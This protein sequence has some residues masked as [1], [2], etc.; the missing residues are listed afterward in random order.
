MYFCPDDE[1]AIIDDL[2]RSMYF[3][4]ITLP[5]F[6][7]GDADMALKKLT[8]DIASQQQIVDSCTK[9]IEVISQQAKQEILKAYSKLCY[10]HATFELRK[11]VGFMSGKFYIKGFVPK[12]D[13]KRFSELMQGFESLVVSYMPPDADANCTPPTILKNSWFTRPFRMLVEMY[14]LPN[15]NGFNPTAFVAVTYTLLFGIMFGDLGQ[16]F[17]VVRCSAMRICSIR[18]LNSSAQTSCR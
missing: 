11:K 12:R 4:R 17:L 6:V 8:Q 5:D 13:K 2:F 16:G 3:E 9:Q 14:G 1:K 18:C 10:L 7:E 15:Y